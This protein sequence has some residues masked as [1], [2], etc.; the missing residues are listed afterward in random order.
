MLSAKDQ[1]YVYS[2]FGAIS[3]TQ[4]AA[5]TQ[6]VVD[7]LTSKTN[8]HLNVPAGVKYIDYKVDISLIGHDI[9][10]MIAPVSDHG[11]ILK[12]DVAVDIVLKNEASGSRT[13]LIMTKSVS[14]HDNTDAKID[15]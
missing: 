14:D 1:D 12:G 3:H 13:A 7:V 4:L 11:R 5:I 10:I 15:S 6:V 9:E 2:L 8:A